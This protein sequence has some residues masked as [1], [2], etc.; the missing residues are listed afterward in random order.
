[1][2]VTAHPKTA[3]TFM[4]SAKTLNVKSVFMAKT[5]KQAAEELLKLE[6]DSTSFPSMIFIDTMLPEKE[7]FMLAY[8]IRQQERYQKI[9]LVALACDGRIEVSDDYQQA[10]FNSSMMKPII[11]QEL[12]ETISRV[13]AQKP[14]DHRVIAPMVLQK[15]SCA[16]VRVLVVE[17]SLP[18]Q[19]LLKIHLEI[20]GCSADYALNGKEA[21]E[22]LGKNQYDVCLMD[23][24]MPVM[25]ALKPRNLFALN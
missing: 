11:R 23:L 10:G 3:E 20:L 5:A 18:N 25:V 6:S 13:L 24:Q 21:L 22:F 19:E 8:K 9:N 7:A 4:T 2:L 17:D 15:I 1:M 14:T 16:G 12:A